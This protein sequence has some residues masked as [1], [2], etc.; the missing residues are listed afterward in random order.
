MK[1]YDEYKKAVN[2]KLFSKLQKLD[3]EIHALKEEWEIM[4]SPRL[5]RKIQDSIGQKKSGKLHSWNEFK[6]I[7][8]GK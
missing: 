1:V 6:K 8:D 4:R 3:T 5:V 7:V 2:G